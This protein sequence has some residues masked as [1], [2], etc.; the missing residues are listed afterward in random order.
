MGKN[1]GALDANVILNGPEDV[2][3]WQVMLR[4]EARA[5]DV[6]AVIT[7]EVT[8][9]VGGD[10]SRPV[11]AFRARQAVAAQ[12][13]LKRISRPQLAHVHGIDDDPAAMYARLMQMNTITGIDEVQA[14]WDKFDGLKMSKKQTAAAHI[15]ELQT[16]RVKLESVFNE[17]VSASK[18]I[19]TL[20][21]SL[22][23]TR[24][25]NDFRRMMAMDF[26]SNDLAHVEQII[27]DEYARQQRDKLRR[28][29]EV[30]S[31]T[32]E[33]TDDEHGEPALRV[34]N[35][36]LAARRQP[37][38]AVQPKFRRPHLKCHTCGGTGHF[39]S[40]CPSE[41]LNGAHAAVHDKE[42][43]LQAGVACGIDYSDDDVA[44]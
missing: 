19:V 14:T 5:K 43:V 7:G 18:F 38:P 15:A 41:L 33:D 10:T 31:E 13:I 4:A 35:E 16:L 11:K 32:D 20:R 30:D 8:R 1:S 40:D 37:R 39:A 25:W 29:M 44:I 27:L 24:S 21:R 2:D 22:P 9:P 3:D 23:D 42:V 17:T 26:Q 36:A 34:K 28:K 12:L 6:W